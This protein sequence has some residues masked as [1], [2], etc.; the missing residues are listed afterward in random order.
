M[1][2]FRFPEGFLWGSSTSSHQVEGHN[3][4]NDWW[5]W[6]QA[7]RVK[8][9]SGAA[10]DHYRRFAGDLDLAVALGHNTHRF[11]IEWSRVEPAEGQWNDEALAHYREV[12][13][14][15]RQRKLEPLVTLHHFTNPRWLLED[16]GWTNPKVVDR[17]ARYTR[18]VAEALGSSVR[19]WLTINEP[20]VY[21]RMHYIQG[22]GPPGARD[23]KQALRVTEHMIRA[24]AASYR[25][26]HEA[27]RAHGVPTEVSIAQYVPVLRP[28]HSWWPMDRRAAVMTER[29]FNSALLEAKTEGRWSIPGIGTWDIPE[30]KGT[31][32]FL[33]V[34][35]YGRVFVRWLPIPGRWPAQTCD[36]GHHRDVTERTSMGWDVHPASLTEALMSLR[37][38]GLRIL[39]T[40]NGTYMQDDAQRWSFIRR[41]IQAVARAMQ[42]GVPVFGYCYWSLLDNF[43]WAEGYG[44]RFGLIETDYATQARRIRDSARR[45]AA[46][47]RSN[48][49]DVDNAA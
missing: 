1:N 48:A 47:C 26:L 34:N 37:R 16:G 32:D 40:E 12:I 8:E 45:Y 19:Y 20:M 22:L 7:G 41:H 4:H 24:H 13:A 17:F 30:A 49:I 46:V 28:C 35:F 39:I 3:V 42:A 2:A 31:L 33:G 10:C 23:L 5:A 38:F 6:E 44:P 15:L 27:G 25:L 11:S 14:A 21:V 29:L 18:R 9:R 36:V 43:E